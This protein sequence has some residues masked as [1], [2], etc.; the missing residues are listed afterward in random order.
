[1]HNFAECIAGKGKFCGRNLRKKTTR[2]DQR[3]FFLIARNFDGL[4]VLLYGHN[5]KTARIWLRL[6]PLKEGRYLHSD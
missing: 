3:V 1:M 4:S 2:T 6:S 5:G